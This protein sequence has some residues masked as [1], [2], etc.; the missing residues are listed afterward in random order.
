MS[1]RLDSSFYALL[2]RIQVGQWT[3]RIRSF[4]EAVTFV[5]FLH[6]MRRPSVVCR[7]EAR[8]R[9]RVAERGGG[10]WLGRAIEALITTD[11]FDLC[12]IKPQHMI[13]CVELTS[14]LL[15]LGTTLVT[16]WSR[17]SS[18]HDL[19][20]LNFSGNFHIPMPAEWILLA[21]D[22]QPGQSRLRV[23]SILLQQRL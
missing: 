19:D 13:A 8:K 4:D 2:I 16:L 18:C 15:T 14:A 23:R 21:T 20:Q 12:D 22:M 3:L 6:S 1:G 11:V 10:Q 7:S 17:R 9:T 5:V